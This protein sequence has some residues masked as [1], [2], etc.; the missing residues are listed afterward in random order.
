MTYSMLNSKRKSMVTKSN[1]DMKIN[2]RGTATNTIFEDSVTMEG[3]HMRRTID[4]PE[5]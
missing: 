4:N 5:S 2:T 1:I 3:S